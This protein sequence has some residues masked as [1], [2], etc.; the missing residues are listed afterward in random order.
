MKHTKPVFYFLFVALI[1]SCSSLGFQSDEL[2]I[3]D[4]EFGI[5]GGRATDP[6]HAIPTSTP[7]SR[8]RVDLDSSS[9]SKS[10]QFTLEHAFG[11][12]TYSPAGTFTARLK[13]WSHGGKTLTKLRFSRNGLTD[14]EKDAFKRLL[15]EDN[16]YTIRVPSN[17]LNP[18]GKG[19]I[20]SS[21]PA[22]GVDILALNYGSAGSC[23]YP[24]PLKFP[25]KW[26]FNSYTVMK[27]S[28]QAR[29]TPTFTE[30]LLAAETGEEEA[31]KAPE[32]SF[33]SKY[34]MYLIPL[35]LIV[36]NAITQAMN[37]PEEQ[38]PAGQS[39]SQAPQPIAQRATNSAA[40][41]R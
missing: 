9:D 25:K 41:R 32:R 36:M 26:S 1:F 8:R 5:E 13:T 19:Y 12:S 15:E 16:F 6:V 33:W 34:W 2:V 21:V 35:G 29:R 39:A 18:P 11:D 40:R 28:E 4:E 37:L 23:Q 24:R 3:D 7:A 22:D 31:L 14:A 27:N 30:E 20:L 10:V 17:V 38:Q